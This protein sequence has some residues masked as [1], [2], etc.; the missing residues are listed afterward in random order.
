MRTTAVV[1]VK[2]FAHAKTRLRVV[3]GDA[4]REA[5][6]RRLAERVV[7]V[8]SGCVDEVVVA[9]DCDTVAAWARA[10]GLGAVRDPAGAA[11]S[12]V[13]DAALAKVRS[14]A[15]L[16]VMADLPRL[17]P[18]DVEAALAALARV[19]VVLGPDAADRG[20]N[21]L[22]LRPPSALATCFGHDDS[23]ERH[24]R[25]AA[26]RSV[27]ILRR[28][29]IAIDVDRPEDLGRAFVTPAC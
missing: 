11:L 15:A 8:V 3:L 17:G 26:S 21:L 16:V 24:A 13:V 29:G 4:E 6:A 1:P 18:E 12:A 14:D 10:K 9:T 22:G 7:S 5:L 19:A 23:F 2:G 27:E 28:P 25:V 20:T